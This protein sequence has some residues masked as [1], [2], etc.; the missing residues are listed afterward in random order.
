[1]PPRVDLDREKALV[2]LL[3][4]LHEAKLPRSAHDL[5]NGGLAV[6]LAEMS[7]GSIG[8]HVELGGHADA[9]DATALLFGE[10]QARAVLATS[11]AEAVLR[12]A[13]KHGVAAVRIGHTAYGTFLIERGGVPLVRT[14]AQELTRVWRSAFALLLG[15]DSIDDVLRG[16]GEEAPEVMA[17]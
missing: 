3:L 15:G 13:Q 11:D 17:H 6:A 10:S 9:L 1:V 16:V 14:S 7:T 12:L 8:C 2:E 4:E 5:G